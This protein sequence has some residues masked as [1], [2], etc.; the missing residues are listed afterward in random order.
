MSN[1]IL[2]AGDPTTGYNVDNSARFFSNT[3]LKR[4]PSATGS[5]LRG[6][7]SVWVKFADDSSTM[8]IIGG[9]DNSGADDDDG[10]MVFM[11]QSSGEL[12]FRGG[13]DIYLTSNSQFYDVSAW[14]HIVL[15]IDSA[16]NS[17]NAQR[18]YVNGQELTDFA[19]RN[20]LTNLQDLP[21][22]TTAGNDDALLIGCDE[23]TGGKGNH[24][25]GYM[26]E[27]FWIDGTQYAASNFGETND[28]GIWI[29]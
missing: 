7:L 17:N 20:N 16:Q 13:D 21:M 8:A 15:A 3:D 25:H 11:R 1:T 23:D 9:W 14:Y 5:S 27:F 28:D 24:F 22:N 12:V 18:I 19:T 6:T 4:L 29:P 2:G 10:Y 26:S